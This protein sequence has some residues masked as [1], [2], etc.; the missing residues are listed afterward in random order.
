MIIFI[1]GFIKL[2]MDSKYGADQGKK[3]Y[4]LKLFENAHDKYIANKRTLL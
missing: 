3:F 4:K 2:M 1:L